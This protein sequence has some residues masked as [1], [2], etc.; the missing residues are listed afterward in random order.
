MDQIRSAG[1]GF[2]EQYQLLS[3]KFSGRILSDGK[4]DDLPCLVRDDCEDMEPLPQHGVGCEEVDRIDDLYLRFQ[5]P[6]PG[7]GSPYLSSPPEVLKN[8]P[9]GL[10]AQRDIQLQQL[11]LNPLHT[12]EQVIIFHKQDQVLDICV[13][14]LPTSFGRPV[15]EGPEPL[16]QGS[17]PGEKR[18]R[19][20][21]R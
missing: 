10:R 12:P 7:Q 6:L 13:D 17:L 21:Q 8:L 14:G 4:L 5:K 11:A 15:F 9:N 18:F 16:Y 3:D 2:G 19:L 20:D 1:Y